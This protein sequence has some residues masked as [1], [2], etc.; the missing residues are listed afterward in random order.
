MLL[1]YG[2]LPPYTKKAIDSIGELYRTQFAQWKQCRNKLT[3]GGSYA[4]TVSIE[5]IVKHH[6]KSSFWANEKVDS[7]YWLEG[8]EV[9]KLLTDEIK[10]ELIPGYE[11]K[12]PIPY[13]IKCSLCS[14][15]ARRFKN[16]TF[17]SNNKCKI[18]RRIK[19]NILTKIPY[20][21][22]L[23]FVD[24]DNVVL[25]PVCG[26]RAAGTRSIKDSPNHYKIMTRCGDCD[27]FWDHVWESWQRCFANNTLYSKDKDGYFRPDNMNY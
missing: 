4:I 17:C 18:A 13:P 7:K 26:G 1:S 3:A 20:P 8:I 2:S 6:K 10:N 23:K 27:H 19:T 14:S 11:I 24:K 5:F 21:R 15:P 16:K 12:A 9:Y 22:P 25:C